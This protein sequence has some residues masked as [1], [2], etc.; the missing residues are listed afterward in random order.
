MIVGK[1]VLRRAVLKDADIT[2]LPYALC[3]QYT[4]AGS[5]PFGRKGT[6]LCVA[7][8]VDDTRDMKVY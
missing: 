5:D 7:C 2:V 3:L 1:C 6:D 4:M 8:H